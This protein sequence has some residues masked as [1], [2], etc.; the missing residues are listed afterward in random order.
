M[1]I[2][3]TAIP[4]SVQNIALPSL[5]VL[6]IAAIL[7]ILIVIVSHFFRLPVNEKKD[8]IVSVLPGANCGGCGFAGCDGYAEYLANDGPDLTLCAVGGAQCIREIGQILGKNADIPDKKVCILLCQGTQGENGHTHSRY[9]YLGTQSCKAANGLLG[10]PGSCTYGCLGFGDCITACAFGAI[11]KVN[12]IIQID[13]VKC[14]ACS[15]CVKVCPK[16]V[17]EL[18]PVRTTVAVLCKNSWPGAQTKKSCDIGC[19]GC[20][21]CE[22][23]CPSQ[24]ITMEGPLAV[25]HQDRC[26]HCGACIE[27]CPTKTIS[28]LLF[29]VNEP[30]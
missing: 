1:M 2:F 10:G 30:I 5:V 17:L 27:V 9:E 21:R 24:A 28:P 14:T 18:V 6:A 25:I 15:Q 11:S 7:G 26:T 3:I 29:D 22:K 8:A 20:K 16:K 12:G 23:V 19:I 13:P 4:Q